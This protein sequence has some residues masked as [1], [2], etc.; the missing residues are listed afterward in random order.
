MKKVCMRLLNKTGFTIA[1]TLLTL[2]VISV[3]GLIIIGGIVGGLKNY[4]IIAKKSNAKLILSSYKEKISFDL[5]CSNIYCGKENPYIV[6]RK[7]N[8][9][10]RYE[11]RDDAICFVAY[12]DVDGRF[13]DTGNTYELLP[14]RMLAL[15]RTKD[16]F[17]M[18]I[19]YLLEED[20]LHIK[21]DIRTKSKDISDSLE[22]KIIPFKTLLN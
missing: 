15:D 18:G 21:L 20:C 3:S 8:S 6:S 7:Y 9:I 11:I 2:I 13:Y 5:L 16:K 22:F 4:E 14:G 19:N 10:G 12:E 1:E 17:T